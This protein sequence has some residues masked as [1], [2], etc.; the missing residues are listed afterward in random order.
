MNTRINKAVAQGIAIIGLSLACLSIC[1][2]SKADEN[3]KCL[4]IVVHKDISV[5]NISTDRLR[6]L[7]EGALTEFDDGTIATLGEYAPCAKRFYKK[8]TNK[9]IYKYRKGW[10]RRVLSGANVTPPKK[11]ENLEEV[12]EF[13]EKEKGAICFVEFTETFDDLKIITVDGHHPSDSAYHL[14]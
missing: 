8:L 14:R 12:R 3:R 5:E 4:A 11:L 7:Y 9:S 6:A 10:I 2:N 13:I 1:L